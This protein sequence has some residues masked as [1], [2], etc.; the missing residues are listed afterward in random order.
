MDQTTILTLVSAILII[1]L[2]WIIVGVRH[3][4]N[5]KNQ[6]SEMWEEI[7]LDLRKRQ[8]MVPN[9]LEALW[10]FD[11][12]RTDLSQNLIMI[13]QKAA[14]ESLPGAKKIELEHDLSAEIN[15]VMDLVGVLPEFGK[16]T[17]FLEIRTDI[18]NIENVVEEKSKKF[19]ELVR[20]YNGHR[21]FYIL[22]PLAAIFRFRQENIF[23]MEI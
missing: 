9:L 7:Y 13:R 10:R 11:Q 1:L 22:R 18:E 3:L 16:D 23:E 20:L 19:N 15:K 4:R 12:S 14:R 8:D 17:I 5:L 2:L 21:R 6:I